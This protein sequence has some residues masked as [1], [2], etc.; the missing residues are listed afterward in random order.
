M[1][2]HPRPERAKFGNLLELYDIYK[3]EYL[4]KTFTAASG[5]TIMFKPDTSFRLIAGTPAGG[6]KGMVA[7]AQGTPPKRSG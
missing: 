6:R 4:G 5:H 3:R 1:P 2:A 7:K